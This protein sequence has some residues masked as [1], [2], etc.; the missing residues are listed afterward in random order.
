[1]IK[2]KIDTILKDNTVTEIKKIFKLEDN[3]FNDV[4]KSKMTI[5]SKLVND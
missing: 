4:D 1:L 3:D 5:L 2:K